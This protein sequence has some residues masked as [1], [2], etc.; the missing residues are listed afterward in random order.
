ML[1]RVQLFV[2][3]RTVALQAPLS[4]GFS[5]QEYWSGLP[6]P[7]L[8][9]LPHSETEPTSPV[10]PAL[11]ADSLLLSHQESPNNMSKLEKLENTVDWNN[12]LSQFLLIYF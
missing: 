7:P 11:Q 8:G 3:P 1:S 12:I 9:D 10:S 6:F 4:M 2:T 5:R